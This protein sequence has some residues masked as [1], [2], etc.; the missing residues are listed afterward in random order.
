[1]W[2]G[3]GG[4]GAAG[5]GDVSGFGFIGFRVAAAPKT[6]CRNRCVLQELPGPPFPVAPL[7]GVFRRGKG[8]EYEEHSKTEEGT[9]R[10]R[11]HCR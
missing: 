8:E 11:C 10:C 2:R 3:G 9:C 4:V 6:F 7:R 1:M 5:A